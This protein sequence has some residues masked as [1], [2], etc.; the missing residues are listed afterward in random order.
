MCALA[1]PPAVLTACPW[2]VQ[3]P[4][5]PLAW[6][7]N[8]PGLWIASGVGLLLTLST[9]TVNSR[10]CSTLCVLEAGGRW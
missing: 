8:A 5:S 4:W 1:R 9:F 3:D 10:F 6:W 2:R 7:R